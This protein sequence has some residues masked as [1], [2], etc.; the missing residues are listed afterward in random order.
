MVYLAFIILFIEVMKKLV[1]HCQIFKKT[2]LSQV[3]VTVKTHLYLANHWLALA[4]SA[5]TQA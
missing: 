5:Q 2:G 4:I 1:H 3:T